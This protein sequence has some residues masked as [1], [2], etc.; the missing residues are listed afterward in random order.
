MEF[1]DYLLLSIVFLG[2]GFAF[3]WFFVARALQSKT[4]HLEKQNAGKVEQIKQLSNQKEELQDRGKELYK[5]LENSRLKVVEIEKKITHKELE[6]NHLRDLLDS[7][8]TELQE[9]QKNFKNEFKV[10]ANNILEEKSK[11]FTEQNKTNIETVLNP[12]QEKI[13]TFENKVEQTNK[14]SIERITSLRQQII[15][16]QNMNQTLSKEANNLTN[17][18][19]SDRKIQGNWGEL[20]LERILEKSGLEK[21]REYFIQ[22]SFVSHD[23]RRSLPDVI[24]HLPEGKKIIIDSKVS[25]TAYERFVNSE[26]GESKKHL[27]DHLISIRRH[28]NGLSEKNY[29]NIYELESLD[30]VLMFLPIEPAFS[31]ALK[32]DHKLFVDAFEKSIIIITPTTLLATLRTI[33]S[34]WTNQKQQSNALE[35]ARQAGSLYDKFEGFVVDLTRIGKR[36]DDTKKD[37]S[38]A[39]IKLSEGKGNLVSKVEKLREMGAK[40]KKSIPQ[41]IIDRSKEHL[42]N[43]G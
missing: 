21:N 28:I 41:S 34:M 22:K 5:Q 13:K 4:I 24:I 17:A 12:L 8:K 3:A 20:I 10:L 6:V 35:I 23:G 32:E 37:Y 26:D 14:E 16:L 1:L 33:D 39:M 40:S 30:F 18:L 31:L 42:E 27:K 9:M 36:M 11:K 15:G 25:L 43:E 19:K 7:Q 2:L 29:Q 38:S